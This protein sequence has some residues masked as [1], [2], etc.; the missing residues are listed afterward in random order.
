MAISVTNIGTA[1][2]TTAGGATATITV[3]GG[4]VP[5]GALIGLVATETASTTAAGGTVTDTGLNT[6]TAQ[7]PISLNG[8]TTNGFSQF[9]WVNNATT[10][11]STN[12]IVYAKQTALGRAT[13]SAFYVTGLATSSVL[14]SAVTASATGTG[15]SPSVTSGTPSVAG[16]LF[17]AIAGWSAVLSRTY[18]QD[19]GHGWA[20]PPTAVNP[21]GTVAGLGGGNQVNA[22]TGTI[23]FTP[24]INAGGTNYAVQIFGFKAAISGS[25]VVSR[26]T[27][28]G[29]A[30]GTRVGSRQLQG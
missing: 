18:T 1:N 12:T 27:F 2:S 28:G 14:D 16:D 26:R 22:G 15:T 9:F 21:S 11:I 7:T 25:S 24:T 19:T 13:I 17:V 29:S 10:L 20:A 30:I 3:P 23:Q 4:G 6:Y 8:V 5:A